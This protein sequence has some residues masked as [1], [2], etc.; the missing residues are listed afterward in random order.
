MEVARLARGSA[1]SGKYVSDKQR[2]HHQVSK[3]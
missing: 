3:T 2:H 1:L